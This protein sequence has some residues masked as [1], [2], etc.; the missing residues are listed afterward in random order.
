MNPVNHDQSSTAL[1]V[2]KESWCL[3]SQEGGSPPTVL[4]S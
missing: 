1:T 2:G 4:L 3:S